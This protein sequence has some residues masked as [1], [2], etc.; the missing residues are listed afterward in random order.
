MAQC[1]LFTGAHCSVER[2]KPKTHG[3]LG[4]EQPSECQQYRLKPKLS[5]PSSP[6]RRSE[7]SREPETSPRLSDI[8]VSLLLKILFTSVSIYIANFDGFSPLAQSHSATL[9][10]VTSRPSLYTISGHDE[11]EDADAEDSVHHLSRREGSQH[12]A[13]AP[14]PH[15]ETVLDK[16]PSERTCPSRGARGSQ[17][18]TRG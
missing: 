5:L 11:E 15:P 2:A 12:Q 10:L 18:P 1:R 6:P 9:K 16:T 7:R 13:G 17:G 8:F 14:R 3:L 4:A